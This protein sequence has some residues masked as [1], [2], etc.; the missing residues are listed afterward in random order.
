MGE[1]ACPPA[2]GGASGLGESGVY[3][4]GPLPVPWKTSYEDGFCSY[5][6]D[7]GFCY[8][9]PSS[10]Y[11]LVTSP[12][13]TGSFAAAFE[14]GTDGTDDSHQA[15][16]VREGTLPNAA[17]YGAWYYIPSGYSDP[18][19][20]NLFHFQ[21]GEPGGPL[22]GTWDVSIRQGADGELALF[23]ADYIANTSYNQDEPVALPTDRWFHLEFYLERAADETGEIALFQDG[24]ELVRAA[25]IV[26]DVN[27]FTQWYVG[28]LARDITPSRATLYVDDV[29]IRVAP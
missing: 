11:R 8:A 2:E 25:G 13:R 4:D 23:V 18:D 24:A 27:P 3:N 15:R 28:N 22:P 21:G 19:N 9:D 29:S 20:W 26:T 5:S 16:C 7:A 10:G 6:L 17:Y 1:L 12:V 14:L